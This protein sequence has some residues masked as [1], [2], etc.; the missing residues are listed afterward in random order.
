MQRGKNVSMVQQNILIIDIVFDLF[1]LPYS[2]GN[3][4]PA[5]VLMTALI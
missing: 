4:R 2:I 5:W 1:S 3:L